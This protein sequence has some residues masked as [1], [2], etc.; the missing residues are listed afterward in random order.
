M[1]ITLSR[2]A[3]ICQSVAQVYLTGVAPLGA[4]SHRFNFLKF[5]YCA[6]IWQ[7]NQNAEKFHTFTLHPIMIRT[8]SMKIQAVERLMVQEKLRRSNWFTAA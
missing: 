8:I 4:V 3:A 6:N 7:F 2:R 5:F 1:L